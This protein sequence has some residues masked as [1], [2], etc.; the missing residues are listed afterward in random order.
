M[1]S[2]CFVHDL[3][4]SCTSQAAFCPP[5]PRAQKVVC[6]RQVKKCRRHCSPLRSIFFPCRPLFV[7][8]KRRPLFFFLFFFHFPGRADR[9]TLKKK[10]KKKAAPLVALF[11][12]NVHRLTAC[13]PSGPVIRRR[14]HN[15]MAVRAPHGPP[16]ASTAIKYDRF[17]AYCSIPMR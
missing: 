16:P 11:L 9:G 14:A 3:A 5:P 10:K 13:S 2:L 15:R 12:P 4:C 7:P 8:S 1:L 17:S 6:C